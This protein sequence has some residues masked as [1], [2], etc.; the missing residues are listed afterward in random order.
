[1]ERMLS[2]EQREEI[3][4]HA[5]IRAIFSSSKLGNLAG[6][7]VIDGFIRRDDY[8]RLYRGGKLLYGEGRAVHVDSMKRL[9]DDVK[10]VREGYDCGLRISAYQDI[11]EGDV[12]EFYA[13]REVQRKLD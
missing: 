11:K 8:I 5:E 10:E 13:L 2:P 4:G 9:K 12:I 3:T 7:H 6:S 1:M